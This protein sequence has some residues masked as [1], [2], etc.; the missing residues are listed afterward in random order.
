M[1]VDAASVDL[2]CPRCGEV[3]RVSAVKLH[4]GDPKY[5]NFTNARGDDPIAYTYDKNHNRVALSKLPR[6]ET[7]GR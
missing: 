7:D 2:T 4:D 5:R 6:P 1:R 3:Y